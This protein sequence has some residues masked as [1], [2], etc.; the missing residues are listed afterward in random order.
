MSSTF[1]IIIGILV[2]GIVIYKL[3]LNK[4]EPEPEPTPI[5][6]PEP[7][8]EEPEPEE[9]EPTYNLKTVEVT[10]GD[11]TA[12]LREQ[13]KEDNT[14]YE[15]PQGEYYTLGKLPTDPIYKHEHKGEIIE[16]Q[17][18]EHGIVLIQD[19]N[20]VTVEGN[21]TELWNDTPAV[22]NGGDDSSYK[23]TGVTMSQRKFFKVLNSKFVRISNMGVRSWNTPLE[24]TGRPEYD[25]H[26]EFEHAIHVDEGSQYIAIEDFKGSSL[27]GDGVYIRDTEDVYVR[28]TTI[29]GN[30]RQGGAMISGNRG[31]FERFNVLNSRRS[32]FDIEGNHQDEVAEDFV[33]TYSKGNSRLYG[34]PMGGP[35]R[36]KNVLTIN[37]Q[38]SGTPVFSLGDGER[39]F[40]ENIMFVNCKTP[41]LGEYY[42]TNHILIDGLEQDDLEYQKMVIGKFKL[43]TDVT[44]RN[45]KNFNNYGWKAEGKEPIVLIESD[46]T[47]LSEF[48][49]YNNEITIGVVEKTDPL[50]DYSELEQD[51]W[52]YVAEHNIPFFHKMLESF[53]EF[54][55]FG[56]VKNPSGRPLLEGEYFK[57][58][59]I[60]FPQY[61][62]YHEEV[63]QIPFET[64]DWMEMQWKRLYT[65][66]HGW[67][68]ENYQDDGWRPE[69]YKE[70][71][72]K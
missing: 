16:I 34:L 58:R 29:D 63:D 10:E 33:I 15:F 59:P 3:Y 47:P 12:Y 46:R 57:L 39:R 2:V 4:T 56:I 21:N 37:N 23:L 30:G 48:K 52:Y 43:C 1:W 66:G 38:Y 36:V 28:N 40:R 7:L 18:G 17:N 41:Y 11:N 22:W 54:S 71:N 65:N 44:I 6:E 35:G 72:F 55:L 70:L 50:I 27:G 13:F 25:A 32:Y 68:E 61:T 8:P 51:K 31:Y 19:R 20:K 45:I 5:P 14:I 64:S 67:R 49:I 62:P 24:E 9:P 60:H 53:E 42:H 26:N 69:W